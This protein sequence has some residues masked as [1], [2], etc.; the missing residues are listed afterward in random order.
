MSMK[1]D[2]VIIGGGAAGLMAGIS[3]KRHN[4]DFKIAIVDRTF[5]LGRKVLVCGAGRCNITN[6]NLDSKIDSAYY[7]ASNNF[8]HSVFDNFGFDSI[9]KFFEDLGVELYVERK[10]DL[11]KLFPVTDQA[12]TITEM[13]IDEINRLGIDIHLNT[14][15]KKIGKTDNFKIITNKVDSK[16]IDSNGF[17]GEIEAKYLILSAGGKSYPALGS[18]GSGYDLAKSLGHKIIQPVPAALPIEGSNELTH[19]LQGQKLEVEVTSV[20]E[21]KEIKSSIDDLIF[22][23]YGLSGSAILNISREISIHFNRENKNNCEVKIN[24]FPKFDA[25]NLAEFL[26]ERWKKRPNQALLKSFYGLFPNKIAKYLLKFY[27]FDEKVLVSELKVKDVD[28]LT[29]KLTDTRIK[30]TGT[31]GWN[32]AEFTA[33]GIDSSEIKKGTLESKKI[34]NLYICGEI[35]DVDGD[36]GGFN[37]SWSWSSGFVAGKLA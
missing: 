15:V 30:V 18:N 8:V 14:E 36:V 29:K 17:T 27:G 2:L 12:K 21:G 32:E 34:E 28:F 25:Q 6:I 7:G 11:G 16:R 19:F 10:T 5:A 20:I 4:P 24:F 37:L 23:K 33:G 26:Y 1:Y 9:V 3:S 22:K 13:M 35:I 31:R